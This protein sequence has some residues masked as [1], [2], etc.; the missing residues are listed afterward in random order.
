[1]PFLPFS[2]QIFGSEGMVSASNPRETST[3]VDGHEGNMES[4]LHLSFPQRFQQSFEAELEHFVECLEGETVM[5]LYALLLI[6]H[7]YCASGI[8]LQIAIRSF[9]VLVLVGS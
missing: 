6:K 3:S 2:P 5:A 4:R 7:D 8:G 9:R 1:M